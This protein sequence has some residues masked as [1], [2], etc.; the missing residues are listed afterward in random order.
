M[1]FL[2]NKENI[3]DKIC[4]VYISYVVTKFMYSS[5][6][7]ILSLSLSLSLYGCGSNEASLNEACENLENLCVTGISPDSN[8]KKE[9]KSVVLL[10]YELKK[11]SH[12]KTK[13]LPHYQYK[14]LINLEKLVQC[15]HKE[16]LIEY[17]PS[18]QKFANPERDSNGDIT[19]EYKKKMDEHTL[20][21]NSKK[22]RKNRNYLTAKSYL[23]VLSKLTKTSKEQKLLY[24]H[25]SRENDNK[26]LNYLYR[27]HESGAALDYDILYHLSQDYATFDRGEARQMMLTALEMYPKKL[28]T[29]KKQTRKANL[30]PTVN[31]NG[32]LHYPILRSLTQLYFKDK[33][34]Y[35]AYIFAQVLALNNDISASTY[36]ISHQAKELNGVN[37]DRLDELASEINN[38]ILNGTFVRQKYNLLIKK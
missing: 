29:R 28:Y 11:Q 3:N 24:W 14:Q 16:S 22:N 38:E 12:S 30:N 36:E 25:W 17:I 18:N 35:A 2:L 20:N 10:A 5:K 13:D 26:A 15:S 33:R 34:Y 6:S 4:V 31:D 23:D 27:M 9:R 21:I 19:A 37:Q 32:R 8:C 7:I 1:P